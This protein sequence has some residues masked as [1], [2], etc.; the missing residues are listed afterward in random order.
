MDKFKVHVYF[1][2]YIFNDL[3]HRIYEKL[4]RN[5]LKAS[6]MRKDFDFNL[7]VNYKDDLSKKLKNKILIDAK[8]LIENNIHVD[9]KVGHGASA[10]FFDI[11]EEVLSNMSIDRKSVILFIIDGDQF[12]P[13]NILDK[14]NSLAKRMI[15]NNILLGLAQ[16][17]R[18]ILGKNEF[19]FYREINEMYLALFLKGRLE[20]KKSPEL[21]I[22]QA[23]KTFG[24]PVPGF[25]AINVSHKNFVDTFK[26]LEKN[27]IKSDMTKFTGDHYVV[28]SAKKYSKILT[29][30]VPISDNPPGN[31]TFNLIEKV[32]HE[33]GNTD[34]KNDFLKVV[35]SK[36]NQEILEKYYPTHYVEKVR[37][38]L[39]KG[40]TS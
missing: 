30:V 12:S 5:I 40:I 15:N 1:R 24:D 18:I 31:F 34:L 20:V 2:H 28:M 9:A 3:S 29:E 16:R 32:A 11:M 6:R 17:N 19:E 8:K 26:Q 33:L 39:L 14:I 35:K 22:P 38:L 10:A 23:Y 4:V 25:Y 27:F 36:K 13:I 7:Q 21:K 37:K